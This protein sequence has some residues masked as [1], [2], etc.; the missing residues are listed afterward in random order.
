MANQ[1]KRVKEKDYRNCSRCNKPIFYFY[2][3]WQ[4]MLSIK[5]IRKWSE[6]SNFYICLKCLAKQVD[7]SQFEVKK[8]NTNKG[9]FYILTPKDLMRLK[10]SQF[11]EG[12]IIR[13]SNYY[14][15]IKYGNFDTPSLCT[16]VEDRNFK[17]INCTPGSGKGF[18]PYYIDNFKNR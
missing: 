12:D 7:K 5:N 3:N 10:A 8:S 6:K 14:I 18:T 2:K 15:H 4:G 1:K 16:W 13:V 11:R 17:P 9:K